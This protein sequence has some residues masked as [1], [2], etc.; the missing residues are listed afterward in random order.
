MRLR[1]V[2]RALGVCLCD[3][4]HVAGKCNVAIFLSSS[5]QPETGANGED[6]KRF[7]GLMLSTFIPKLLSQRSLSR[8]PSM[9]PKS[10]V[11]VTR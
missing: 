2:Q 11:E 1:G 6:A 10:H 9:R 5:G 7:R 8:C 3:V 4:V